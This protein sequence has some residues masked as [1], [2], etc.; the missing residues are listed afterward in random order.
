MAK[1]CIYCM[2]VMA[3]SALDLMFSAL[4]GSI[5]SVLRSYAGREG[6]MLKK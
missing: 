2:Q 5:Y 1:L 4:F 6:G 3:S